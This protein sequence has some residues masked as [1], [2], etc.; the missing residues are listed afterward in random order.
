MLKEKTI[1]IK[2]DQK[3]LNPI[4]NLI[5]KF[6]KK[7]NISD[8]LIENFIIC[9]NEAVIN[10]IE[11]N[12]LFDINNE[13][14]ITLKTDNT[15]FIIEI[16]DNGTRFNPTLLKKIDIKKNFK[17][18]RKTGLGIFLLHKLMDELHYEYKNKENHLTLIKKLKD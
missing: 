4:N 16:I 12:Y 5:D 11:H 3:N 2:A 8:D 18:L 9:I 10:I 17:D 6:A 13:I 14:K 15:E 7:F 1:I